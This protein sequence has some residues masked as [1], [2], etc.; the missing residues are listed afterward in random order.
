ML[1]LFMGTSVVELLPHSENGTVSCFVF[2]SIHGLSDLVNSSD[3]FAVE[4]HKTSEWRFRN[5]GSSTMAQ[6]PSI[7]AGVATSAQ[8]SS[9]TRLIQLLDALVRRV[10][11]EPWGVRELAAELDESRSTVNRILATL[12]ERGMA[13]EVGTGKYRLG[14]RLSVLTN[15]LSATNILLSAS[16]QPLRQLAEDTGATALISICCPRSNGYFIASC[17]QAKSSLMFTPQ[18]GVMYPLTFGDLGRQ[19]VRVLQKNIVEPFPTASKDVQIPEGQNSPSGQNDASCLSESEFPQPI[20]V[21]PKQL[22]NSLLVAISVHSV[23]GDIS[24][25]NERVEDYVTQLADEVAA[26]V[27]SG[28]GTVATRIPCIELEDFKS[29]PSRLERLLSL[30]S[31]CPNGV[32]NSEGLNELLMCNPVTGQRLIQSGI[33]TDIVSTGD[34]VLFPGPKLYQW[35]AK[36][37]FQE[38]IAD[39]TRPTVADLVKK[40]GETIAILAYD[41]TTRRAEFVD[42]IQ[43]WRPIQYQ[44]ASRIDVPLYAGAAGKAVLAYCD[45]E[46][47][48]AIELIRITDATITSR[49]ELLQELHSIRHRGWATGNGER[50]MGAFGLAVPF[51]ADGKIRGSISATI[52]QYR[53]DERDL[54]RLTELMLEASVKI[55]RLLSLGITF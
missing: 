2:S 50:V 36:I 53:K 43:G 22:A 39:L 18:L 3:L 54:P 21:V 40:T 34:S 44:L 33:H 7:P 25:L 23:D 13:L 41:G 14:P 45:V 29:T 19:F 28:V 17:G 20:F 15:A 55:E 42:V 11:S 31:S 52:P 26:Q 5:P 30:V 10:G 1:L 38:N 35:A 47:V 37:G 51:F 32:S 16:A 24:S 48:N 12:V 6:V 8:T 9:H 4:R 49:Q 27:E 46:T